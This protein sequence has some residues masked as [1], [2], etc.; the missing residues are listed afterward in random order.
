[1]NIDRRFWKG[2]RILV[3]G[4]NGFVGSW[5]VSELLN[6]GAYVVAL[7]YDLND[8]Q[9]EFYRSGN[10]KKSKVI[11]GRLEDYGLLDASISYY[12]L[13]TIFHLGAQTQVK[14]AYNSP[15]STM[16]TNIRG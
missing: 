14:E 12:N 2:R 7:V 8:H 16:E 9:S 1:M 13:N 6:Q 15:L 10:N 4:A 11:G 5:L 3:T